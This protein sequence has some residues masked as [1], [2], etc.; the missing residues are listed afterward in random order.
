MQG[1]DALDD[2]HEVAALRECPSMHAYNTEFIVAAFNAVAKPDWWVWDIIEQCFPEEEDV[3][4]WTAGKLCEKLGNRLTVAVGDRATLDAVVDRLSAWRH[5]TA[6]G[7]ARAKESSYLAAYRNRNEAWNFYR[8][9]TIR[10][11]TLG[12]YRAGLHNLPT[13]PLAVSRIRSNVV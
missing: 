3:T 7:G 11:Q 8:L 10:F 5:V 4:L 2:H 12:D 6:S 1:L 9:C 13:L